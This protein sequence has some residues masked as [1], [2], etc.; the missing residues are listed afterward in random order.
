MNITIV[1]MDLDDL[2]CYYNFYDYVEFFK[3]I[4][5][6][7]TLLKK[8]CEKTSENIFINGSSTIRFHSDSSFAGRGFKLIISAFSGIH[9]NVIEIRYE[10]SLLIFKKL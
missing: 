1:D 3:G 5:Q 6:N 4:N 7:I 8:L 9:L 10:I 2:G